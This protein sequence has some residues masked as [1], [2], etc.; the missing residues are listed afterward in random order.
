MAPWKGS[1]WYVRSD[2]AKA[3][4]TDVFSLAAGCAV[5]YAGSRYYARDTGCERRQHSAAPDSHRVMPRREL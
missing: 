2:R 3:A 5:A 4:M 1:R